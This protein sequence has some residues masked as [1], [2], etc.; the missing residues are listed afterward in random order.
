LS[1][2]E[3]GKKL[4]GGAH[5]KIRKHSR[6][7]DGLPADIRQQV[8]RLLIEGTTYEQIAAFLKDKG[9]DLSKSSVGRYGKDFLNMLRQVRILQDQ[10]Q[11]LVSDEATGLVAEEAISKLLAVQIFD[12]LR[13]DMDVKGLSQVIGSFSKL[14]SSNVQRER[15]K[16]DL[17]ERM[18]AAANEVE[19]IAKSNGLSESAVEEI[20]N[21][22]LGIGM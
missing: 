13:G 19:T 9:Y 15:L 20:K 1:N 18:A 12:Q 2:A 16:I 7:E 17:K 10:A 11:A 14:Q 22:I 5:E 6:I 21:K 4:M 3:K 8:D